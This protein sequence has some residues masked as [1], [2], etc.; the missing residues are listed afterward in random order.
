MKTVFPRILT[1]AL[2]VLVLLA[3]SSS[4]EAGIF[5]RGKRGG[6]SSC[7]GGCSTANVGG[8][9]YAPA[10]GVQCNGSTC[11]QQSWS[12]FVPNVVPQQMPACKN[13]VCPT[14]PATIRIK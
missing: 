10:P 14:A 5:K 13:G 1:L 8:G 4:A 7:S 3:C 9:R 12:M 6:C 11:Q 2:A